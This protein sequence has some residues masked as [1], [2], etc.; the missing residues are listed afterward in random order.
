M[1]REIVHIPIV[2]DFPVKYAQ[3]LVGEIAFE[4]CRRGR[5]GHVNERWTDAVGQLIKDLV[6]IGRLI[7]CYRLLLSNIVG[8]IHAGK[9]EYGIS[10]KASYQYRASSRR[11]ASAPVPATS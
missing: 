7:H 3:R 10:F 11:S 6:L 5:V 1:Q 9:M 4:K 2:G 8:I